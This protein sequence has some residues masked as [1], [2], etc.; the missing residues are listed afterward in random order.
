MKTHLHLIGGAGN[1]GSTLLKSIVTKPIEHIQ[2]IWIYCDS[3]KAVLL[4]RNKK[5]TQGVKIEYKPYSEFRPSL[6][7]ENS[8]YVNSDNNI[9]INMRGVNN[10]QQWLNQPLASMELQTQ[11]CLTITESKLWMCPRVEI[12]HLSSQ[13]CELIEGGNSLREICEGQESYRRPY[14]ISRLHQEEMLTAYAFKHGIST[15]FIR[16]PA[17]YGFENDKDSPWVLNNLCKQ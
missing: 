15:N 9:V 3:T 12:I 13:L 2:R 14:M 4:E 17:I 10:K 1:I 7:I 6:S 8:D 11:A 16:L 5:D